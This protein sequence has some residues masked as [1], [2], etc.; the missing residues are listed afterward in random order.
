MQQ[1]QQPCSS[2][3]SSSS[4][5]FITNCSTSI[6]VIVDRTSAAG[7]GRH[8]GE[9]LAAVQLRLKL[10]LLLLLTRSACFLL[11]ALRRR[12]LTLSGG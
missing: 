4:R 1:V 10:L 6:P 12:L 3:S 7:D 11:W 8:G 2:S 9:K 5:S